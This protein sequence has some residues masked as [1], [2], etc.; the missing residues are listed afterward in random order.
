MTR[1]LKYKNTNVLFGT[2]LLIAFFLNGCSTQTSVDNRP[3][4]TVVHKA[5][6][7]T[8]GQTAEEKLALAKTINNLAPTSLLTAQINTLLVESSE[9]F[10]QQQNFSKALWLAN[11][12]SS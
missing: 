3:E 11:I 8:A 5:N 4:I 6:Q 7:V 2:I 10:F 12:T 9:L 1:S